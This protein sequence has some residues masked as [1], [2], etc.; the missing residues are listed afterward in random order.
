MSIV[1]AAASEERPLLL[2]VLLSTFLIIGTDVM[3]DPKLVKKRLY[4]IY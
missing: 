3:L 1:N 4:K 2:N